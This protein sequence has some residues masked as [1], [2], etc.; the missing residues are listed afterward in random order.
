MT[1]PV[2]VLAFLLPA[3][4]WGCVNHMSIR[5]I[6]DSKITP[7]DI[8]MIEPGMSER[9]VI[10]RLGNPQSFGVDENGRQYLHYET[11]NVS[12]VE[13]VAIIPFIGAAET[14][15]EIA[16]FTANIFLAEGFVTGKSQYF[17]RAAEDTSKTSGVKPTEQ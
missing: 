17:Y 4:L 8:D 2:N 9:Q 11:W 13:K 1:R 16:G 14:S 15:T 3:L 10:A 5:G 12:R 6:E 7:N